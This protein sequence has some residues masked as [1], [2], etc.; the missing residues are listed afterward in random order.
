MASGSMSAKKM[1]EEVTCFIC[2]KLMT[3]PVSI[4]C[5]HSFC[6]LCIAGKLERQILGLPWYIYCPQCQAPFKRESLRPNKQLQNL[7]ETIKEMEREKLCEE[8][9]EKLHLFCEDDEQLICWRCERTPPHKGHR[10]ALVED[11][12]QNYKEKLQKAV[13]KLKEVDNLCWIYTQFTNEQITEWEEKVELRRQEIH[14]DFKTLH[15]FL[16]EEEES[17]LWRLEK[18]KEQTLNRLLENKAALEKQ[19]QEFK[20][21]ILELERKCQDSAQN[22][23]QDIKDSL[24]RSSDVK[25]ETQKLIS[26][27]LHTVCNVSELYFDVMK[28]L[29]R[30][31]VNVTLDPDT[32]HQEL[33]LSEDQRQVTR[34]CPQRKPDTPARFR[35]LPCVLGFESFISGKHYFEVD[36]GKGTQW[37]VGVCLKNVSR[38]IATAQAPQSG[39]WVIRL[40]KNKSYLALTSPPTPLPLRVQPEVVGIIL[41]CDAGLVSFYNATT[42]SHIY[43]FPKTSFSQDV[44]PYLQA[45][46]YSPLFLP[47]PDE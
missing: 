13:T 44:Q 2:Q 31:Q 34:G 46:H 25:M 32:A 39:F 36:V 28:M 37:D 26:L 14:S 43:T 16:H 41:D 7:I 8:H 27:E 4:D 17:Y 1:R 21:H 10:T 33:I 15:N 35:V 24:S 6:R 30:Y 5:G 42:G 45:Y 12:C 20:N 47:S 29:K 19:S 9:G 38:D 18:E 40:C 11:V 23:L 3:E 22:L